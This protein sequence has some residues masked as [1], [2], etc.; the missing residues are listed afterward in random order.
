[1]N[2]F[3]TTLIV[4]A[5]LMCSQSAVAII[6]N[7]MTQA[8]IRAYDQQ[9]RVNPKDHLTWFR[10]ANEYYRHSEYLRALCLLYTSPSPRD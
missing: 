10:R 8:V 9:L 3:K 4:A 2:I 7:P 6:D 1:M 5:A